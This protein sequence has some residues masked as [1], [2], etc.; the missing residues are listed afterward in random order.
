M[1]GFKYANYNFV[2][3]F[4][5]K[6]DL[7]EMYGICWLFNKNFPFLGLLKILSAIVIASLPERRIIAIAPIPGEVDM[8]Q[9]VDWSSIQFRL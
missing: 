7:P 9:I 1:R 6:N 5:I 4:I 2:N 8:A 3:Y